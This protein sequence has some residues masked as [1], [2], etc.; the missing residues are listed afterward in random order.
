MLFTASACSPGRGMQSKLLCV[1]VYVFVCA[2]VELLPRVAYLLMEL[3]IGSLGTTSSRVA[4]FL[5]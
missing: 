4:L 2:R 1:R 5:G 3:E